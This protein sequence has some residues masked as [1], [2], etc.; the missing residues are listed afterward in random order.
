MEMTVKLAPDVRRGTLPL[1]FLSN[2]RITGA[3]LQWCSRCSVDL[4]GSSR[5]I[6]MLL[7]G[8]SRFTTDVA[9]G[10]FGGVTATTLRIF[11]AYPG[12]NPLVLHLDPDSALPRDMRTILAFGA[13]AQSYSRPPSALVVDP[14]VAHNVGSP[15]FPV[16]HGRGLLPAFPD[17]TTKVI[18]PSKFV[19]KGYWGVRTLTSSELLHA[20]DVGDGM[21]VVVPSLPSRFA[22]LAIL[23]AVLTAVVNSVTRGD[24]FWSVHSKRTLALD[25]GPLLRNVRVRT[26]EPEF[27]KEE[28]DTA[29][30][31]TCSPL[32]PKVSDLQK[33]K[34][35]LDEVPGLTKRSPKRAR[36]PT[37][38]SVP[39]VQWKRSQGPSSSASD[40]RS[41]ACGGSVRPVEVAP[42]ASKTQ[43]DCFKP[44][45]S[46]LACVA[47]D[48]HEDVNQ[49]CS[50]P[51]SV[52][53]PVPTLETPVPALETLKQQQDHRERK[54]TKSDDSPVPTELWKQHLI[55]DGPTPWTTDQAIGLDK[56]M[57][58]AQKYLLCR[59]K[60]R[61]VSDFQS[62]WR[63]NHELRLKRSD[64]WSSKRPTVIWNQ[65]KQC[66]EWYK[67][68]SDN[69][70]SECGTPSDIKDARISTP[71]VT[72]YVEPR[73]PPG[74]IGPPDLDR[75]SGG[76]LP[77][78]N[79]NSVMA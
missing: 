62:W 56:A 34:D 28:M 26:N 3:M 71:D 31:E 53:A 36:H 60:H 4:V 47:E 20:H 38:G 14:L 27:D 1:L 5:G 61:T 16:Y 35:S 57:E 8:W 76:G 43:R 72:A 67:R 66:Y 23:R 44:R 75:C 11:W 17:L 79:R 48:L 13:Q 22:P 54:A 29:M 12:I 32:P 59:W 9:H 10:S 33:R 24:S 55:S 70:T 30:T 37:N 46:S 51:L 73:M 18:T 65:G 69:T 2:Y 58:V 77:K 40:P 74:G 21:H 63:A 39:I 15:S 25:E 7:P 19:R 50:G 41:R 64:K 42:W 68:S 78:F 52:D 6:R 45:T 49:N